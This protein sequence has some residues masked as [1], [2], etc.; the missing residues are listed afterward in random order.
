[1][2]LKCI[3]MDLRCSKNKFLSSIL[4][5]GS[6][7]FSPFIYIFAFPVLW[8]NL[9]KIFVL[10]LFAIACGIAAFYYVPD[11]DMDLNNYYKI[12]NSE[13]S[14]FDY[15]TDN[16]GDNIKADF[17]ILLIFYILSAFHLP[18]QCLAL[19]SAF[20]YILCIGL[21]VWNW[22]SYVNLGNNSFLLILILIISEYLLGFTGIRYDNSVL[23]FILFIQYGIK[24]QYLIASFFSFLSIFF[25]F[26]MIPVVIIGWLS[27]ILSYRQIKRI[28]I[29]LL[30]FSLFFF[31]IMRT[32]ETFFSNLGSF[33]LALSYAI[34]AY[35]FPLDGDSGV[36]YAGSRLW[37][38]QRILAFIFFLIL[39]CSSIFNFRIRQCL[40]NINIYNF[41]VILISFLF[42]SHNNMQLFMRLLLLCSYM[43]IL[44]A[45]YL[46]SLA[47]PNRMKTLLYV[48]LM[49]HI[50]LGIFANI[51]GREFVDLFFNIDFISYSFIS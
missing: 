4:L 38:V 46:L 8:R 9:N 30:F 42:F 16:S 28:S 5:I 51:S 14:I 18:C 45:F 6:F 50:S 48:Y 40:K 43:S 15:Y 47:L 41:L 29:C 37:P 24:K 12:Y 23:L 7:L 11:D 31:P 49:V 1:M 25:H 20:I 32:L 3:Q 26:A 2:F 19:I 34:N 27:F 44:I 36:L 21:I 13:I 17:M 39:L 33:G 35:I 22:I 10:L